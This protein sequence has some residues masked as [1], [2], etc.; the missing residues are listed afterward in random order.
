MSLTPQ[1][2]LAAVAADGGHLRVEDRHLTRLFP[3]ATVAAF[4]T[5]AHELLDQARLAFVGT[6]RWKRNGKAQRA[7]HL[8]LPGHEDRAAAVAEPEIAGFADVAYAYFCAPAPDS[9]E[10]LKVGFTSRLGHTLSRHYPA[11]ADTRLY[12]LARHSP[13]AKQIEDVAVEATAAW[14][15]GGREWFLLPPAAAPHARDLLPKIASLL[16]DAAV[17][18]EALPEA[19]RFCRR[20]QG[21]IAIRL[22][23]RIGVLL[24]SVR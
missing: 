16:E 23:Q 22:R 19:Q 6:E 21:R 5:I 14:R 13:R 4:R 11:E 12:L 8:A 15:Q 24:D 2:L 7:Y 1:R 10:R 3:G 18:V 9:A 20:A 17:E